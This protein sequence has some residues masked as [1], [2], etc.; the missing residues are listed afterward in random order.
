M[1]AGKSNVYVPAEIH[2]SVAICFWSGT[3]LQ[4][5]LADF[6]KTFVRRHDIVATLEVSAVKF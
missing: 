2:L 6:A 3:E 5:S 4:T 1:V